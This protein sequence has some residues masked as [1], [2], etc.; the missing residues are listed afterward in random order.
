MFTYTAEFGMVYRYH[1]PFVRKVVDNLDRSIF[2]CYKSF[3][4]VAI[5][6]SPNLITYHQLN[7]DARVRNKQCI[8]GK[9]C[10]LVLTLKGYLG[11]WYT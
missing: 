5:K 1:M 4:T 8:T 10:T 9:L 11:I 6:T 3:P 7:R 2:T